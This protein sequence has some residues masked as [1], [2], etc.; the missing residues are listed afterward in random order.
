MG[1]SE[2]GL[3]ISA[4]MASV[5]TSYTLISPLTLTAGYDWFRADAGMFAM[6]KDNSEIF[7]KAKFSF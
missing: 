1:K 5:K 4:Y 3:D 2:Y 7:V 6:Y